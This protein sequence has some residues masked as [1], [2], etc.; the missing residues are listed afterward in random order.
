MTFNPSYQLSYQL[1]INVSRRNLWKFKFCPPFSVTSAFDLFPRFSVSFACL[2]PLLLFSSS[3]SAL[4]AAREH[5]RRDSNEIFEIQRRCH[6][7]LRLD[8]SAI[9][10]QAFLLL[11]LFL[12]PRRGIEIN[13]KIEI[14]RLAII[15]FSKRSIFDVCNSNLFDI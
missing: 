2:G 10:E 14:I 15:N 13:F 12:L 9:V 4:E 5:W 6:N 8:A 7:R 11:L 1:S 3:L